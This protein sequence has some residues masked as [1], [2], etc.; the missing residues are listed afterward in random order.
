MPSQED[1][2]FFQGPLQQFLPGKDLGGISDLVGPNPWLVLAVEMLCLITTSSGTSW[3]TLLLTRDC[4]TSGRIRLPKFHHVLNP[5][6]AI[7][8]SSIRG[9]CSH[10][11]S[12]PAHNPVFLHCC[13]KKHFGPNQCPPHLCSEEKDSN[14]TQRRKQRTLW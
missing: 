1:V 9:C 6:P 2:I 10:A 14:H 8:P 13:R 5:V 4:G 11:L 3:T 7:S 12:P